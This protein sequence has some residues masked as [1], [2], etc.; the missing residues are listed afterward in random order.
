M[1]NCLHETAQIEE[2]VDKLE[3]L[4]NVVCDGGRVRVELPQ[5]LLIYL[6]YS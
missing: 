1:K 4:A 6:T 5:V 2:V 3:E